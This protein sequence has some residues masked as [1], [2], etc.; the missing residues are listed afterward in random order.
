MR[1]RW[2]EGERERKRERV[3]SEL[4]KPCTAPTDLCNRHNLITDNSRNEITSQDGVCLQL[5]RS[6]LLYMVYLGKLSYAQVGNAGHVELVWSVDILV[7]F[8]H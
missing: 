4:N 8:E 2:V 7:Y 1:G 6:L 3:A 5:L